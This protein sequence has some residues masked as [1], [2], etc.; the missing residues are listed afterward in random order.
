MDGRDK[1]LLPLGGQ[2]LIARVAK[3][4]APQVDRLL[5]NANGDAERFSGLGLPVVA[6]S[7]SEFEGPLAGILAGMTWA[8]TN[9]PAAR[10][11]A[12]VPADTPFFPRDLVARLRAARA[13]ANTIALARSNRTIHQ[14]VALI[15]MMLRANLRAWLAA[16]DNRAVKAWLASVAT[17]AVDFPSEPGFDPFFNINT[18]EDLA[19]AEEMAALGTR[20]G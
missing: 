15:P 18:P 8:A 7:T 1:A 13:D 2:P 20:S 3:R 4:L 9:V 17:V 6:D 11:I 16:T 19:R 5:I 10:W 14:V 12:T